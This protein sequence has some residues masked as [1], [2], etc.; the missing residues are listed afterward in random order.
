MK[1]MLYVSHLMRVSATVRILSKVLIAAATV[2]ALFMGQAEAGVV[3]AGTRIIFPSQE[4]EV[5]IKI[6]N[7]G[8]A[9]ALVQ[10]WL[11]RGDAGESPD[12]IEV[13]FILT[14]TMFRLDPQKGQTLRLIYS[15]EPLAQDKETL[16]WLNVLEIPPKSQADTSDVNQLQMAFRTRIKVLFRPKTLEGKVEESPGKVIWKLLR[17]KDE[18]SYLLSASNPTPYYVNLGEV[19]LKIGERSFDAGA[20]FVAPGGV[21]EFPLEGFTVTPAVAGEVDYNAINDYG[22]GVRGKASLQLGAPVR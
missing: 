3:I 20:G 11:D 17:T 13:P 1:S 9:P 8:A 16:F 7:D 14:P 19:A 21:A 2:S 15:K 10:T 4:R 5:T 22:S 12:K 6:S 18:K